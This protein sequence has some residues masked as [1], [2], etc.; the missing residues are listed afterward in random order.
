MGS[1]VSVACSGTMCSCVRSSHLRPS[2]RVGTG[3]PWVS[4]PGPTSVPS[5]A[6]AGWHRGQSANSVLCLCPSTIWNYTANSLPFSFFS[7]FV[8]HFFD[9]SFFM[10]FP[11]SCFPFCSCFYFLVFPSSSLPSP[12]SPI[13]FHCT[14]TLNTRNL[15]HMSDPSQEHT[16]ARQAH[17][18]TETQCGKNND[19]NHKPKQDTPPTN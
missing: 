14:F 18:D 10:F 15:A 8:L 6:R 19:K 4:M 17:T 16:D 1:F 9:F 2:H 12:P 13:H 3:V 11:F 5:D 7:L